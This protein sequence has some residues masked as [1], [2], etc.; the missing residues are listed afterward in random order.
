MKKLLHFLTLSFAVMLSANLMAQSQTNLDKGMRFIEQNAQKWGLQ[1]SDYVNSMVSDMYTNKKTGITYIYLVQAHEG[2]PI[3]NAITPIAIDN[4]GKVRVVR[5]GFIPDAKAMI[6]A[7]KASVEPVAAIKSAAAHLGIIAREMPTLLRS[8][9]EKHTYEFSKADFAHNEI[10]VKLTYIKDGNALKLAWSLAID[11][12]NSSDYYN[13]FVDANTG[14]VIDKFNYTVKCTFHKNKYGK[15]AKHVGCTHD[16]NKKEL[17]TFAEA[18]EAATAAVV[19]GETYN[20]LAFPIE[21]PIYGETSLITNPFFPDSSPYGWH[22]TNGQ[23]GPE[24]SITRGNNTHAYLDKE[25]TGFPSSAEPNG[26]PD[27]IFD[28]P[29]DINNE[30]DVNEQAATVNLFYA[31]NMVH[32]ITKRLGFDDFSGNFQQN[33]Y[34]NEGVGGDYVLAQASDGI[35]MASPTLNNANFATPPDG[36]NGQMQMF[37]WN[38]PSGLLTVDEPAEISGFIGDVITATDWGQDIPEEGQTPISGKVVLAIEDAPGDPTTVCG[39]IRNRDEVSGNI[40]MV[41]RGLCDFSFKAFN[42]QEAGAISVIIC[43]VEGGSSLGGMSGGDNAL[44][45]NIV[46]VLISTADCDRI[47]ASILSDIDV[48][49]TLQNRGPDGPEFL[50]GSMDNGIIIH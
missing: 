6:T 1:E 32:D 43:D 19:T 34:E 10:E 12:K 14:E 48:F 20:A 33:N 4:K 8:D 28:L 46:P 41:D 5:H 37:L 23:D 15:Q 29:Y 45:V 26:G 24:F 7:T 42:A 17:S 50:D 18:S 21:S 2:I 9:S 47:K 3:H 40:A 49:V 38:N 11:E 44:D 22:D 27:L 35:D 31:V 39:P 16:H 30:A 25:N 36:S 13:T